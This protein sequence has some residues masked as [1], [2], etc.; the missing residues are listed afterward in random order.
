MDPD[1]VAFLVIFGYAVSEGLVDFDVEYPGMILICFALWMVR[2]L[3]V[4]DW[5]QDG[6]AIM[7]VVTIEI[8]VTDIDSQRVIV[9]LQLLCNVFFHVVLQDINGTAQSAY[10]ELLVQLSSVGGGVNGI[11]QTTIANNCLLHTVIVF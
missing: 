7:L 4:E 10:P 5:P 3:I 9:V 11:E 1:D 8:T 6:F 2:N